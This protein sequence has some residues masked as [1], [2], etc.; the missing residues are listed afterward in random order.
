MTSFDFQLFYAFG[1]NSPSPNEDEGEEGGGEQAE[2]GE[3]GQTLEDHQSTL[4]RALVTALKHKEQ[5][6]AVCSIDLL[7][8][9]RILFIGFNKKFFML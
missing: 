7:H 9:H 8:H 6:L 1:P 5:L 2:E 4:L 3:G